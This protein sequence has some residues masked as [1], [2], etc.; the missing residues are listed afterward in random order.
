MST[1][2]RMGDPGPDQHAGDPALVGTL[3][4]VTAEGLGLDGQGLPGQA[5]PAQ[6]GPQ[7]ALG[8]P[9]AVAVPED[10]R[11]RRRRTR[12][13]LQAQGG[14]FLEELGVVAPRSG[15]G[16]RDRS[17]GLQAAG[18][19]GPDPAVEGVAGVA[20]LA[21]VGMGVG[22]RRRSSHHRT[23]LGG[24]EAGIGRLGNHRPAVQVEVASQMRCKSGRAQA[25]RDQFTR[26]L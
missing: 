8:D 2:T 3:G 24:A 15:V 20:A 21:P 19:P 7:G 16:P 18:A 11:D 9:H 14:R 25:P 12:R 4:L 22:A 6:L 17:Q 10:L 23:S 13:Q 5:P 26:R 1:T